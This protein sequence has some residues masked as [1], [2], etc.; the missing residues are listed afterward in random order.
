MVYVRVH[1]LGTER[2]KKR[3][4][5]GAA[6]DARGERGE[7]GGGTKSG[8]GLTRN[9]RGKAN[10]REP[11]GLCKGS[12]R[13]RALSPY[14]TEIICTTRPCT[15]TGVGASVPTCPRVGCTSR[16]ATKNESGV[17]PH[18]SSS[19]SP[20][21]EQRDAPRPCRVHTPFPKLSSGLGLWVGV[22]HDRLG[23][24]CDASTARSGAKCEIW[25]HLGEK[26]TF[27]HRYSMSELCFLSVV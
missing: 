27:S 26:S 2:A 3:R 10:A 23:K 15:C 24:P 22:R 16:G 4:T 7:R 8:R 25:R 14:S 6:R 9:R 20:F 21:C 13:S 17:S 11:R 12:R 19:S 18:R 5:R 1:V